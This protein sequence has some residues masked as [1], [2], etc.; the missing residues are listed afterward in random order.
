M[1]PTL[2]LLVTASACTP[3]ASPPADPQIE[4][5]IT[6]LMERMTLEEKVGQMV[7][8]ESES[9]EPAD[10]RQYPLGSVLSG[11]N[12]H[13]NGVKA[14]PAAQ[15]LAKAD[16]FYDASTDTTGGRVGIPVIWGVDAVHGN[17][18]LGGAT[19]FPHNIGLGATR[20]PDLIERIGEVTAREVAA[21]GLDWDFAPTVAVVRD[22]RWGRTYEGYSED[23]EIVHAYAGRMVTGLQGAADSDGF[24]HSPRVVATAKHYLGDGGTTPGTGIGGGTDRG[25][26]RA[27]EEELLAIHGQGY[28]AA[29]DAGVQTVM[30]SYSSWNGEKL[31]GQYHLLT[32]VLKGEM[33]F[34]GFVIGDWDGHEEV[35][36]CTEESCAAAINAGI[37]MIMAPQGWRGFYENTIAQVRSGEI[38]EARIDDAVRRI[39]RVKARAGLLPGSSTRPSERVGA[40]NAA[41]VGSAEHRAIA[42][43]AVRKS[44][45]LL[46]NDGGLLPLDRDIDVLVA[47]DGADNIPKQAGGWSITWQ[48]R[49]ENTN[50]DFVGATSIYEGIRQ[51]VTAGGGTATLSVDGSF[52]DP[53]DVAIVVFGEEPY[54]EMQGDIETLSFSARFPE[55]VQLLQRLQA[56][57]IP[58]V[59]V[60][61][62][63]RPLWVNPELDAS[64]AFVAAWLPGSEGAGVADVLFRADD[65][66]IDYDFTGTLSFS[67]PNEPLQSPLNRNDPEYAPRFPYGY[68]MT[69][70]DASVSEQP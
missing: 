62:S 67:W 29:V 27:T 65:G 68:G 45:V 25:D 41:V 14:A 57:G 7:Q 42:R 47:G 44:L 37:D 58:V 21:T 33:G 52:A 8:G 38:P 63:G 48:N 55:P 17:A 11:G 34:D 39:L 43:E 60:F 2:A 23:P 6:A 49:G 36:G 15:W 35:P 32:E 13:P 22:D 56:T 28:V 53:P 12:T 50:A 51:V 16:A 1:L 20:D 69:Y 46:Q 54:A 3:Q 66:G 9:V 30:A 19:I 64:T 5:E 40:G 18:N 10:L 31:H 70:G 59:S 24:L 26:T 4:A 61:L